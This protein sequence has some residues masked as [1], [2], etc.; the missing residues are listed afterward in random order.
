VIEIIEKAYR[1]AQ[2]GVTYELTTTFE[3]TGVVRL[4]A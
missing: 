2:D 1:A 4:T 3:L